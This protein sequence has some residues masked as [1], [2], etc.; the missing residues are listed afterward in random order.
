MSTARKMTISAAIGLV[1]EKILSGGGRVNAEAVL[2]GLRSDYEDV[3]I[4]EATR[5]AENQIWK[6]ARDY[7]RRGEESE[8]G[9]QQLVLPDIGIPRLL[10]IHSDG[11]SY[12]LRAEDATLAEL[13]HGRSVR[14]T[15]VERA[16]ARLDKYEDGLEK[17]RHI[18]KTDP[19]MPLRYALKQLGL[20]PTGK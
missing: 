9:E 1:V 14:V 12:F 8:D 10:D 20:W 17:V 13:D 2:I 7:A 4:Q 11:E 15:N 18:M 19:K 16:Q 6:I 3:L 5:L